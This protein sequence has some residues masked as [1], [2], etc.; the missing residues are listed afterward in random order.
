MMRSDSP[1]D[2]RFVQLSGKGPHDFGNPDDKPHHECDKGE[3][4]KCP[5]DTLGKCQGGLSF[6]SLMSYSH[7]GRQL[8]EA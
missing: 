6:G 7:S 4:D 1:G 2:P 5:D 8:L 3:G